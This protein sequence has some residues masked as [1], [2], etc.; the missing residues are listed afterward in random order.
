MIEVL[1]DV[2]DDVLRRLVF[3]IVHD[4]ADAGALRIVTRLHHVALAEQG[5]VPG[6]NGGLTLDVMDMK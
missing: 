1:P 6:D 4:A 2:P 3:A 5:F